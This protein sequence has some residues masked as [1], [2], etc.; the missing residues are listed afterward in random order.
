MI[1]VQKC[2]LGRGLRT[3]P[4]PG[5]GA[6]DWRGWIALA[7]ALGCGAPYVRSMLEQKAPGMLSSI[8][9]LVGMSEVR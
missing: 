8:L 6:I 7:W 2:C 1:L 4:R 5:R 3:T 9:R